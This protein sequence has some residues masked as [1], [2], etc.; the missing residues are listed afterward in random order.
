MALVFLL[1]LWLPRIFEREWLYI[2]NALTFFL[3]KYATVSGIK[4]YKNAGINIE[5]INLSVSSV[6]SCCSIIYSDIGNIK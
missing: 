6:I 2:H 1:D 5:P 3:L 4:I